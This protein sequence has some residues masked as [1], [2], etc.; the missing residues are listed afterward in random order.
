M[1]EI[2][3]WY[4]LIPIGLMGSLFLFASKR[5]YTYSQYVLLVSFLIYVMG[6]IHFTV[7]PIEV[8]IGKYAN[9][10]PWY[11]SINPIPLLTLDSKSFILNVIMFFPLGVYLPF[12]KN[13]Y[14][15]VKNI[16]RIGFFTSI[17]IEI[18]QLCLRI[19]AGNGRM[20]D[21]NDLIANTLGCIL[22]YL[23]IQRLL[24]INSIKIWMNHFMV[25][26]QSKQ[27]H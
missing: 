9:Q 8:N 17:S 15:A 16:A 11:S 6:V 14:H 21:I 23:I 5:K 4:I 13:N 1:F 20:M 10:A 18:T 25:Y 19:F 3:S 22:G 2:P 26:N 12:L 24:Q 7:F 27:L